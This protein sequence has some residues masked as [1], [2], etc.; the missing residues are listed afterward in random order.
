[1]DKAAI[2]LMITYLVVLVQRLFLDIMGDNE[3]Q[4][5]TAIESLNPIASILSYALLYYFVF[6]LMFITNTVKS[7][8]HEERDTN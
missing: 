2:Y 1:M 8:T 5:S 6:E 7:N 3:N 4:V